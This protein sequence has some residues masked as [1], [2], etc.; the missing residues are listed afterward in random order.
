[1]TLD[2]EVAYGKDVIERS[3]RTFSRAAALFGAR[4]RE[5]AYLLY[6]WARYCDDRI[7]DQ[8]MGRGARDAERTLESRRATL[9]ELRTLTGQALAGRPTD[10]PAYRCIARA[11]RDFGVPERHPFELLMGM[12]M[13][14]ERRRYPTFDD[15]AGY[16]YH[17]AGALAVMMAHVLG[18]CDQATLAMASDVG[19]AFQMTNTARDV[20]D[21][22]SDGRVYLPLDWLAEVGVPPDEVARPEHRAGVTTVVHRI[23]DRAEEHY[24]SAD[25]GIGP[26][27]LREAWAI[28][29]ARAIYSDIGTVIR[30]RGTAAW[31]RRAFVSDRR[32]TYWVARALLRALARRPRLAASD[33]PR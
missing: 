33:D 1:M 5:G 4:A 13:D 15:L 18:H 3:S 24:R 12:E 25:R 9:T 30:R 29:S 6:G 23:L 32:K 11:V 19:S 8:V 17:V 14:V 27:P 2:P 22:A 16:C 28:A 7:D 21:D 10:H 20:L 26:L 31:D